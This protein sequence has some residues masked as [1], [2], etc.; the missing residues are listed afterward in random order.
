MTSI[1]LDGS[2]DIGMKEKAV[3]LLLLLFLLSAANE[4]K[5][6]LKVC[7]LLKFRP[8]ESG[9]L[10]RKASSSSPLLS[11]SSCLTTTTTTTTLPK[12]KTFSHF[13]Y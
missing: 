5:L 9:S 11:L 7:S 1:E 6:S 12:I 10:A 13:F 3:P 2:F 8:G 4:H